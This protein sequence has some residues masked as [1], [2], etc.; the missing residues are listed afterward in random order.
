MDKVNNMGAI[1]QAEVEKF[2]A[3][4]MRTLDL[5]GWRMEWTGCGDLCEKNRHIIF[6]D[7]AVIG[8]CP[9]QAK[10]RVLHET[11]HIFTDDKFHS[12]SFY[13]EYVHLLNTFMVIGRNKKE[14]P[15]FSAGCGGDS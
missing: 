1:S 14:K 10:E 8:K 6:I 7:K 11:A 3:C 13:R 2:V 12:S 4:V 5:D 15:P 9:W